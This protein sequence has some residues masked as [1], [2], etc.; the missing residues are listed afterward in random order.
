VSGGAA[1]GEPVVRSERHGA[2]L[3]VTIDRPRKRNAISQ[4]VADGIAAALD[5]LDADDELRVGVLTGAGPG[6]SA[7]MDLVE[8][9]EGG[10]SA[11][12]RRGF[13]GIV[14]YSSRKPVIAAVEGFA[15]A[16]GL[17]IAL[18]CDLIVAAEGARLGIPEAKRSL[19]AIGG[20]LLR[21]PDR[22]GVG[23]ARE[24]AL[25]GEPISAERGHAAGL[26]DR[27]APPGEALTVAL[28][29]AATIAANGPLAVAASKRVL[30]ELPG[31]PATELW[32]RQA[33]LT[34]PTMHSED[35]REG[36]DAF[37]EK[38]APRWAGR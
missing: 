32:E 8:I 5:E 1:P 36:A 33:A 19:V 18:A 21:L 22:V 10:R 11:V 7:G 17:E 25:T 20:G 35:A 6:F 16:G 2:T 3:V 14:R 27:L 38:R 9:N 30:D 31:W 24:L 29:L 13:A 4:A 12:G 23:L 26:V 37:V 34:E 28:E 15:L